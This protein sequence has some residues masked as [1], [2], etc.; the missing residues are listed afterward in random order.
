MPL[1]LIESGPD[2]APT[3]VLLHGGGVG[4]WS[5]QE[6]VAN[7]QVDYHC[8]VPDLPEHGTTDAGEFTLVD[9]AQHVAELIHTRAH[10]GRAHLTGLS[11]GG[12]VGVALL[13]LA[14]QLADRAVLSGVLARPPGARPIMGA[15][16][17]GPTLR[18]YAPFKNMPALI[19][20]NMRS[21]GVP[22]AYYE[23]FALDT[24]RATTASLARILAANLAFEIPS[25]LTRCQNP[26]LLLVGEK[27]PAEMKR[28]ARALAG[29]M[30]GGTALMV[31]GAI[32]NWPLAQPALFLR[33]LRA[34]LT[35]QPLL[36]EL[37]PVPRT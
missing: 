11:L 23:Q 10:D 33:V 37:V 32:H 35:D 36:P 30:L 9:A 1:S 27:E 16:L 7:L 22:E 2:S 24:R 17:L 15:G 12:Q 8:L 4:N 28:S 34:W 31:R 19:R 25:G 21:L 14:P 26:T 29:A 18:L 5:W 6:H 3:L 13:G 20:A